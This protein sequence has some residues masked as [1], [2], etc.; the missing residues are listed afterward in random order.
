MLYSEFLFHYLC[1]QNNAMI[2][3]NYYLIINQAILYLNIDI[4]EKKHIKD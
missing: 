3:T 1:A 4:W 2:F